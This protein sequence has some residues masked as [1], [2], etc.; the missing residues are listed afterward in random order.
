MKLEDNLEWGAND[1]ISQCVAIGNEN[2]NEYRIRKRHSQLKSSSKY[3]L[4]NFKKRN[5]LLNDKRHEEM[6][7]QRTFSSCEFFATWITRTALGGGGGG[8]EGEREEE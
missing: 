4:S 6:K 8:G 2:R 1:K 5:S 3:F 7:S